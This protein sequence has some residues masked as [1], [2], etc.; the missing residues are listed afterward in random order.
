MVNHRR[1][2]L[3]ILITALSLPVYA[4]RG[5]TEFNHG[6][7]AERK[8]DYDAA[9]EHYKQAYALT[10]NN[11][12]YFAAYTRMRFNAAMQHVHS[13]QMLRNTGGLTQALA[14]FQKAVAIDSSS[15]IAQQEVRN[16]TDLIRRR[17]R[18]LSL[19][20]VESPLASFT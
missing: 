6:L 9:F 2:A 12:K 7:Q 20:K 11:A 13:G 16:T 17:E 14:E 4:D 10:P 3:V 5:K 19:P 15:F 1:L 18:V 8:S